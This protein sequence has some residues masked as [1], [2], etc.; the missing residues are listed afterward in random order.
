MNLSDRP[1][2]CLIISI[3]RS[4]ST[5]IYKYLNDAC[6]LNLPA[7]KEPHHWC[8]IEKFDGRYDLL[9][10]LY[11]KDQEAYFAMYSAS[12]KVIDASVG[13]FFDIEEVIGKLKAAK[14]KPKVLFLYR[15]PISRAI[16]LFNELKKKELTTSQSIDQ[17]I[18]IKRNPGL[19]WENYFDNVLYLDYFK[20]M[21]S[22]FDDL[23]IVDYN[24]FASNPSKA[25]SQIAD[26]IGVPIV[27]AINY[28]PVNSSLEAKFSADFRRVKEILKVFRFNLLPSGIKDGLNRYVLTSF[29]K[30]DKRRVYDNLEISLSNSI[31]QYNGFKR[32]IK[33]KDVLCLKR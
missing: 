21:E 3:G 6:V 17:E 7:N 1:V 12:K 20:C 25:F 14:Q 9:N 22:Y 23:M 33:E 32:Y 24:A 26:F 27:N 16:S 31:D 10:E 18:L 19:W 2:D 5:A 29:Y 15:D 11:I 8:D 13:Y 30:K 4:A 28:S